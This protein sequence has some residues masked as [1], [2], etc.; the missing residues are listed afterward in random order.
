MSEWTNDFGGKK[1]AKERTAFHPLPFDC[2]ALTF[3]PFED[4]VCTPDGTVYDIL[5]V[6]VVITFFFFFVVLFVE[7]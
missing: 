6:T 1:E 5:Y 7:L 3:V 2:C 4:P